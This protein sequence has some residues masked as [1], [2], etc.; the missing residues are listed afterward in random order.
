MFADNPFLDAAEQFADAALVTFAA[1]RADM[2]MSVS[3]EHNLTVH[4]YLAAPPSDVGYLKVVFNYDSASVGQ[5]MQAREAVRWD[6]ADRE[7]AFAEAEECLLSVNITFHTGMLAADDA[8]DIA[9]SMYET[10]VGHFP[11]GPAA[12]DVHVDL[13]SRRSQRAQILGGRNRGLTAIAAVTDLLNANE[14]HGRNWAQFARTLRT[15]GWDLEHAVSS[16][17]QP[18]EFPSPLI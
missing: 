16:R 3:G 13:I 18:R 11:P 9:D 6:E 4:C 10:L 12:T 17:Q 1:A 14:V 7:E 2:D 5:L 15:V 8:E